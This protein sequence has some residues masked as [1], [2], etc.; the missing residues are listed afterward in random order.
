MDARARRLTAHAIAWGG[1][2]AAWI[3]VATPILQMAALDFELVVVNQFELDAASLDAIPW[4]RALVQWGPTPLLFAALLHALYRAMR[5]WTGVAG[6]LALRSPR[7]RVAVGVV[8]GAPF[9]AAVVPLAV[10][11]SVLVAVEVAT[12][13]EWHL[14]VD[15]AVQG[16][17]AVVPTLAVPCLLWA[18]WRTI[19]GFRDRPPRLPPARGPGPMLLRAGGAL[20]G[21]LAAVAWTVLALATVPQA[22]R[23]VGSDGGRAFAE[24]CGGCH[25]RAAPLS[26]GKTPREWH[27]TVERMRRKA[28]GTIPDEDAAHIE[29][30]LTNVRATSEQ[31][32][33]R[34]RCQRCHGSTWRTW[35]P[36]PPGEWQGLVDRIARWSPGYYRQPV[37]EQ[38][39]AWLGSELGDDSAT[40][41][42][43]P[44]E[45]E[46]F[47]RVG[48]LCSPCHSLSWNADDY[49]R[50]AHRDEHARAMVARMSQ[51]MVNP[52]SPTEIDAVARDWLELIRDPERFDG[53]FP[54]DRP[55]PDPTAAKDA[56]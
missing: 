45:W 21:A 51:K 4:G 38:V 28:P 33:F 52:L 55:E 31:S 48:E 30:F 25:F 34:T 40:L 2:A 16:V 5:P 6:P 35:P 9:R 47:R 36:R 11:M 24:R 44:P 27:Q 23:V 10:A 29:E 22:V 50:D 39:V 37:A 43:A 3:L 53:L 56:P 32:A 42:L 18:G 19:Q 17:I 54:H 20:P 1:A 26:Y 41:G 8:L 13:A 46:R 12:W 14:E 49:R 15:P 7:R